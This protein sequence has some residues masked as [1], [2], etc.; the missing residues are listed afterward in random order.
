MEKQVEVAVLDDYQNVALQMADWSS[1]KAHANVTV[2]NDHVSD[3]AGV[4]QRLRAFDVLCVMR[5]RT[6]LTKSILSALPNVKLIVSAGRRNASIDI[7]ACEE[8][9]I[10]I[11]PTGYVETGAVE[12]TWALLMNI[13]RNIVPENNLLKSGSDRWQTTIGVDLKGKTIGIVGL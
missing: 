8:M 7:E 1:V 12:L 6:P 10:E 13:S 5:E 3:E 11:R 9:G 4:I 2:F